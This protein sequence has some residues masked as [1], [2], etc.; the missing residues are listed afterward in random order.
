MI[1]CVPL[2]ELITRAKVERAGI[3]D[4]PVLSMTRS[5]GLV[6]QES[7]FKKKVASRDLSEYK[8]VRP[9]QL[10][11]GIHIDEGALGVS[12]HDQTGIVSPAYV[13][14][15]LP[16]SDSLHPD[17]LHRYIR[18]P[19]AIGHFV[20]NYRQTAER[21]GKITRDR[22]L[23]LEVPLPPLAEQKRIAGILDAADALR[24]KRREALAQLDTL[25]QS[26]FLDMF[27]DP[28]SNPEGWQELP[29]GDL[30]I[31]TKLGLVRSSKEFGWDFEVPYVRMD[32]I[33]TAGE[34]LPGKVQS[35]N[36][37]EKEVAAFAL[38]PRDFLFN[39]RNSRDLV[40]KVCVFPGPEGWLF[41]N[42][43]MRVRFNP[44]VEPTVIAAQ[45]QF[46]RVQC[47]LERRKAGTTSVFAVYWKSLRTL[48]VL[49]P[50]TDLQRRF[51]AVVGAVD[52]LKR[53]QGAH[54][55]ELDTLFGSLQS[56]AFSG[57]L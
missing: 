45:F 55:D 3:L 37:T 38:R 33:S 6:P 9:S 52:T 7:V 49:V 39:T 24:A 5:G 28:V 2:G 29:F 21:R 23:A 20:A 4:L 47:E 16:D 26:T 41:N 54:L 50:P 42:N 36:A 48:P 10:V 15:D 18:S 25:L 30:V 34:F 1:R 31:D 19:P 11:V 57:D 56:R 40:G 46:S 17:Y 43:L 13:L 22:F 14:W 8:V 35:T 51:A 27:G 32:A 44:D 12:G 53:E